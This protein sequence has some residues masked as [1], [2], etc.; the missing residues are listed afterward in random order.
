MMLSLLAAAVALVAAG[1]TAAPGGRG[2]AP[3]PGPHSAHA[4]AVSAPAG[5]AAAGRPVTLTARVGAGATAP[6]I[7]WDL[8]ADGRF[9]DAAG[10]TAAAHLDGAAGPHRVRVTAQWL[11]GPI[12]ITRTAGAT[13]EVV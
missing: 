3:T 2:S 6:T 7:V 4:V 10:P 13:I 8:D 11:D 12:L 1:A 5:A 9:D